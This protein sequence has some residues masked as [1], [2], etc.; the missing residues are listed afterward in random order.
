MDGRI[1]IFVALGERLR[2]F[3][4]DEQSRRVLAEAIACNEWF[5]AEDIHR[6]IDAICEEFLDREKLSKW[7]AQYAIS[8]EVRSVEFASWMQKK[9]LSGDRKSV[10]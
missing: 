5:T 10:V 8:V 1:D 4:E 7:V 6:A 9:M 3:G 2:R